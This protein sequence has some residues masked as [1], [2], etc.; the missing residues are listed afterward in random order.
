MVTFS[1]SDILKLLDQIPIW[2]SLATMPRRLAELEA[3]VKVL[4]TAG[5]ARSGPRPNECPNCHATLVF[6][7][8]RNDSTFGVFGVKVHTLRCD[9]CGATFDRQYD[10]RKG[11]SEPG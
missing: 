7:G 4:E 2:K 5:G 11:Y 8:E 3:R 1:V 6:A 9:G 10:P